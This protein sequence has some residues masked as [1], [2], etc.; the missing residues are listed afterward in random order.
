M[1]HTAVA[2]LALAAALGIACA[3]NVS[4]AVA[5]SGA[6]HGAPAA[7]AGESKTVRY[8]GYAFRVPAGWPVYRLGPRS[9]TCVRYDR[10]AVYLGTPGKNQRCP[11]QLIGQTDTVSVAPPA[12]GPAVERQSARA[13][14]RGAGPTTAPALSVTATY[15]RDP[16]RVLK[17]LRSVH[18][19]RTRTPVA[20]HQ[21]APAPA[22]GTHGSGRHQA[23][24]PSK[25]A[26]AAP[27]A[28]S[29]KPTATGSP[30]PSVCTSPAPATPVPGNSASGAAATPAPSASAS[31]APDCTTPTPAP[32]LP[33]SP[34][35]SPAPHQPATHHLTSVTSR[36][37]PGFDTCTAPSLKAMKAW[38]HSYSV[39]AI[40]IGGQEMA[41]G[42]GNLSASWVRSVRDMGWR[43]IPI[44]VGLQAPCNNF[45]QE[46]K[47]S[48]ATSEGTAAANG[49][50]ADA[51][52]FGIGRD[53]P[54][55]FD[56][57]AYNGGNKHCRNSVL[58]FLSQWTR[59]LHARDY[60]S[61]VYSS[62]SS[63]AENLGQATSVDGRTVAKPNSMWF[64]L[65]NNRAN[66]DG[67]PYLLGSWWTPD[68]R[69]KQYQGAHKVKVDGIKLDIDSD[70]VQGAVY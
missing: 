59:Q 22:A 30:T 62:A 1:R 11:A 26:A 16:G 56:M 9:T 64:A 50:I 65:W 68:R 17:I 51:K 58:S 19:T 10:H 31:S 35:T 46:I 54:L 60:V 69:I 32:P 37:L 15:G 27:S 3:G 47:A 45:G 18:S 8:H 63:G 66:T 67:T 28:A 2:C 44:Y 6:R 24:T 33:S 48:H 42:Y 70:W 38:R 20:V 39:A 25:A 5:S 53:A 34:A 36:P 21:L 13:G 40:Y 49:A 43:L 23:K 55:Y 7:A 61:G 4:Q 52:A 29:P 57:E 14:G 12:A 41:C